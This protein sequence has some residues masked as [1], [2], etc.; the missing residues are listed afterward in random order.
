MSAGRQFGRRREGGQATLEFALVIPIFLVILVGM[1]DV[2]RTIWANNA[3]AN[4]AREGARYAIVHGGSKSNPCPVG[5]P[6]QLTVVPAASASCPFPSPSKESIRTVVTQFLV[7]G[8]SNV[9]ITVCYG[10]GCSGDTD[11]AGATNERGTPVTVSV[12][13][14][15][16]TIMGSLLNLGSFNLDATSTMLVNH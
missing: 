11:I 9:V 12:S 6:A 3:L 1:V 16:D 4:A 14:R 10:T 7:G 5:P 13:S 2:G 8:G 15:V